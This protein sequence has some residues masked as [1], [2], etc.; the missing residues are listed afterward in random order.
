MFIG[1]YGIYD[2]HHIYEEVELGEELKKV[3]TENKE[4]L[5]DEV[6]EISGNIISWI[7]I[8]GTTIDYPVV[9]GKDNTTYLNKNYKGEYSYVGSIFLDYRNDANFNDNYS[10]IYG[11]N[12][13]KGMFSDI[14]KFK[15]KHFFDNHLSGELFLE[16]GKYKIEILSFSILDFHDTIAYNSMLNKNQSKKTIFDYFMNNAINKNEVEFLEEPKFVLLSTCG[17]VNRSERHV[18]LTRLVDYKE[19]SH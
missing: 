12:L 15:E 16:K 8:E 10:I 4:L 17:P 9:K 1:L 14:S 18:L 13:K 7:T 2:A 11:H 3:K 6:K 5:Y 19:Y